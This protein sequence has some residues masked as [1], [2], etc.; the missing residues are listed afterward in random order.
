M[1]KCKDSPRLFPYTAC[2]NKR[3]TNADLLLAS[4]IAYLF[5]RHPATVTVFMRH[6]M[7]CVGCEIAPFH[8]V[9]QVIEL[10]HLDSA[11][12]LAELTCAIGESPKMS[13]TVPKE[14]Q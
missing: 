12:L 8:T 11:T 10:Y 3:M 2:E 13:E 6:R 14:S 7:V 9:S 4:S 5:E 1:Q